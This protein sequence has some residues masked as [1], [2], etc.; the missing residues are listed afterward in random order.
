M[1]DSEERGAT[2]G[3]RAG[4]V[5]AGTLLSR[6]LGA[7]RDAVIAAS[8]P[9]VQ[10]DAFVV[11][12]TIPNALRQVLGE[13]AMSAAVVPLVTEA[14]ERRGREA[15]RSL[16]GALL[17]TLGAASVLVASLGVLAAPWIVALYAGGYLEDPAR[18]DVT[19]HLTRWLFPYLAFVSVG[20]VA[21]GV[22]HTAGR[23]GLPALA[24]ALLNVALVVSPWLFA[25]LAVVLGGPRVLS[26]AL[27]A[28]LGGLT[29]AILLC[30]GAARGRWLG[31][32]RVAPWDPGVREAFLRLF[33]LGLGLGVYQLNLVASRL[34]ASFLP[35]GAQ[36][37]LYYGQRLVEIPQGMLAL[38]V[39]TASLPTLSAL[40]SRG[41][42]EEALAVLRW[43]LRTTWFLAIPAAAL[44][45]AL[46]EPAVAL[47]FGRGHFGAEAIGMTARSLR[48]Q[49]LG[50]LAVATV[51]TVVPAFHAMGETRLPVW[52]SA[53]NLL[54]FVAV[55]LGTMHRLGH[56][57]IALGSS[58]AAAAQLGVLLVA[59]RR[60]VGPLG[61]RVLLRSLSKALCASVMAAMGG[62]WVAAGGRWAQGAS[63][64]A[65]LRLAAAGGLAALLYV[66]AARVLRM[67]ELGEAWA[68]LRRRVRRA[69]SHDG[70]SR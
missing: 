34:L 28:L 56:E 32:I 6:L 1:A 69:E 5:A 65:G 53:V 14:R 45:F 4:L 64:E 70:T 39:A 61:A 47:V 29:Q 7:L 13:G 3:R 30:G 60:R 43:G 46:A 17:G 38:A 18:F 16:A 24:P 2:L 42:G 15:A 44:L 27:G 55:A 63:L 8:F 48:W 10:T 51:R 12:F 58:V 49:A 33:P 20:A 9:L 40:G 23:F 66:G 36:S 57:G 26:L 11:A 19:V 21:S 67:R 68:V 22:L 52:A 25:P 62:W 35:E 41:R 37:Y 54:V 31:R 50:V 59:L